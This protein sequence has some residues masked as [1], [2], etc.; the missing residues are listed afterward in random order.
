MGVEER[1][2]IRYSPYPHI[3]PQTDTRPTSL[4]VIQV[5]AVFTPP[6]VTQG[7]ADLQCNITLTAC[8][9]VR[10]MNS[11]CTALSKKFSPLSCFFF[12]NLCVAFHF[13]LL[14]LTFFFRYSFFSYFHFVYSSYVTFLFSFVAIVHYMYSC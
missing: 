2:F 9:Q 6:R 12:F 11:L 13:E 14:G 7:E 3:P 1:L 8:W 10:S 5:K 4:K